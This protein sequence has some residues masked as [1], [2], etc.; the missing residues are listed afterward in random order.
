MDIHQ[1]HRQAMEQVMAIDN[2]I[3]VCQDLTPEESVMER[4]LNAELEL[5]CQRLEAVEE[6]MALKY[7]V[8]CDCFYVS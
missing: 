5:A 4:E 1:E 6:V 2:E 7:A 8:D 3:S